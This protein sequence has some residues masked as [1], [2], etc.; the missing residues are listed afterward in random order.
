MQTLKLT[1][2]KVQYSITPIEGGVNLCIWEPAGV[3]EGR[4][5]PFLFKI[6]YRLPSNIEAQKVLREYLKSL[7]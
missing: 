5:K 6:N 4:S 2:S 3:T 7:G 1:P